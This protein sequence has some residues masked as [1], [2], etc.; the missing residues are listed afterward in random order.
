MKQNLRIGSSI[1]TYVACRM[2][3]TISM[4]LKTMAKLFVVS[5]A[6]LAG[7]PALAT[8]SAR[9]DVQC[10]ISEQKAVAF[11]HQTFGPCISSEIEAP[12]WNGGDKTHDDWPANM[13]LG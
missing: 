7:S 10:G 2:P 11:R 9:H 12:H 6:I 3:T 4:H 1:M 13:I 8:Q 5:V